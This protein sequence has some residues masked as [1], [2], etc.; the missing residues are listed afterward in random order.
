[1]IVS[2]NHNPSKCFNLMAIVKLKFQFDDYCKIYIIK[3]N[4][5]L[6]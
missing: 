4:Q 2:K 3:L 6:L 5:Q 1:M